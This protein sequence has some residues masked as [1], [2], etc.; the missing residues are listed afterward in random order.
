MAQSDLEI[1]LREKASIFDE[2]LDVSP[3]SPY[4]KNVIQPVLRRLGT[5]PFTVD[6]D[7]FIRTRLVQEF[8]EMATKEGDAITDLL[9]KPALLLWDPFLREAFRL[10]NSQ[11]FRDPTTLT[12]DEADALGANLFSRRNTGSFARGVCRIYYAQP[13]DA[14]VNPANYV[15]S[16]TGLH[17]YPTSIQSLSVA[18]MLFNVEDTLYYFD[19]NLIAEKAGDEYNIGPD[20][21]ST[22]ANVAAAVR[23][24]N[25]RRFRQGMPEETAIEFI[26]R[27]E[28]DLTERSLVT[29]RGVTSR[30]TSTFPEVSRLGVVGFNDPEMN[31]DIIEGGGLGDLKAFG[32]AATS[33]PDGEAKQYTRRLDMSGDGIDFTSIIGPSNGDVGPWVLTLI[34]AFGGLSPRIRDLAIKGIVSTTQIDLVDQV[35]AQ[36]LAGAYVWMLRKK[37]L[38]LSGIP[39]GILFPDGPNGTVSVP[40]GEVHV[41]GTADIHV[42]GTDLDSATLLIQDISDETPVLSGHL[43]TIV[44]TSGNV[45]LGDFV[46]NT[47]YQ[48]DDATYEAVVDAKNKSFTV[49]ILEGASAGSYRVINVL[50]VLG[51]PA[52]LTLDPSP[53]L[54]AGSFKWRL[55]DVL[56]IDLVEPKER[57]I[58]GTDLI[59]IQGDDQ[60]TTGSGVDFDALGVAPNDIVRISNGPDAGDFVVLQI[61]TPFF[62]KVQ[63]NRLLTSSQTNLTYE[64]FRANAEGGV[65]R[66]LVRV[67]SIDLLDTSSQPVGSTIPYAKPVGSKSSAF[68]NF[69]H[70]VKEDTTDTRLGLVSLSLV[71]GANVSGKNIVVAWGGTS[72]NV[73]FSGVDP[74]SVSS[75]ISQINT[76]LSTRA[77]YALD[78]NRFGI[79]S[80][81]GLTQITGGSARPLLFGSPDG[82]R[83]SQDI[84]SAA[85]DL[86]GGWSSVLTNLDI[87]LDVVQ[88]LDGFQAGFYSHPVL[89]NLGTTLRTDK[90]FAPE[91]TRRVQIGSRSVG[92][93]R[94]YFIEPTSVE[95][96]STALFGITTSDGIKL[97]FFPDPTVNAQKVPALPSGVKPTDGVTPSGGGAG[98]F[99]SASIDFV[100][101]N[102]LPGDLLVIDFVP[103]TGSMNLSDPVANLALRTLV[104]SVGGGPDKTITFVHDSTAIP[105]TSVTRAGVAN[106]INQAAGQIICS[107]APIGGGNF[108]QFSLDDSIV[109][110]KTGTA[111]ALLGFLTT[112]DQ[113][114]T[115]ENAGSYL[116]TTV[117]PSQIA[118]DNTIAP[119]GFQ[120][121]TQ[122]Q[123]F[124][125]FRKGAQRFG[126]T[127]M[128][129]Q[130]TIAG[131]YYV[132][133][134]LVS[135]GTG[136]VWNIDADL[137]FRI[138][139]YDS[140]GYYLTTDDSDLTFSTSE[141]LRLHISRSIREVGV[142]DDPENATQLSGQNI[143][144]NYDRSSL[145][146]SIESFVSSEIERVICESPLAR[147]LIP[148]FI[149]FDA[150]YVGG[151]KESIVIPDVETYINELFPN[152]FLEV[153]DVEK[154][155][156]DRGATSITNPIDLIAVV[157]NVDRTVTLERSQDKLNTGRL[158]AFIPDRI[159][160]TR[161]TS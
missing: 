49:Q 1:F 150:T 139:G 129:K 100:K 39:G 101:K 5:D 119:F 121:A 134:E 107:I 108:L 77:A 19:I 138:S 83:T 8:P 106:Q 127:T 133:V 70:G 159:N 3:G 40:D 76:A 47:N 81:G 96:D 115:S 104:V 63:V 62:N 145:V 26:D 58:A 125:I 151:S 80:L 114:N 51:S 69:S 146:S 112:I 89:S 148:H 16:K 74:I 30:I 73:I 99:Q 32:F 85:V 60:L 13:Q 147:H 154:I 36:P 152:D 149:R 116:I 67:S 7:T 53:S 28:Q 55:L 52:I 131:L 79:T 122:Q 54:V 71:A 136:D 110:R 124:K 23:I 48:V 72:Q 37:E 91:V 14:S 34:D 65:L 50:Q 10:R 118:I 88:V 93:A 24:T 66:P 25:K 78:G 130:T 31:R 90:N 120:S 140:D 161:R 87:D 92:T 144:I 18:E 38:T 98:I 95:F 64:I 11:S 86:A 22:I 117:T 42:R 15:S 27:A 94:V 102:I 43:L 4:D 157:H 57:R 103:V 135:Q 105:T 6:V 33:I 142:T 141:K 111:N 84:Q 143:Q 68:A 12:T 2:N 160:I 109:I 45:S 35:V 156:S 155:L 20:E 132:D 59:S 123:G 9:T 137:S 158:A 113:N 56:D 21:L 61:P 46:L 41:G 44:D 75:I 82:L 126:S 128:S 153:S 17:F 97:D 29:L